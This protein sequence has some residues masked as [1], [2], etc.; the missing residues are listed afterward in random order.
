M[1]KKITFKVTFVVSILLLVVVGAGAWFINAQEGRSLEKQLLERGRIESILGAK[2]VG[3][4]LEEA[5]DNGVFTLNEAFDTEYEE[6]PGFDPPK[7]H[8]KYDFY[9]DK[10]ILDLQEEFFKDPSITA[11]IAVDRNG[12]LPTH[13]MRY[14]QPITGD[15]EKDRLGNHTKQVFNDPIGI[16]AA[17]NRQ[18]GFLQFYQRGEGDVT[19]DIASPIMVKGKHWGNFRIGFSLLR[20]NEEK[21]SLRNTLLLTLAAILVAAIIVIAAGIKYALSPLEKLTQQVMD[22]ADGQIEE[23]IVAKTDDEIGHMAKALERL[24]ISLRAAMNRLRK[25][26]EP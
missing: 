25:K 16:K 24:R 12:Y 7:Y 23:P 26:S 19:W 3:R 15:V 11:A 21:A 20:T 6:I 10:A 2:I 14:Q 13:N 8:T 1:F 5:I 18:E 22:L 17:Q 9:L 4:I